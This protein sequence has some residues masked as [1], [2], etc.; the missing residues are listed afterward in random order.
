MLL[1]AVPELPAN[2]FKL[3]WVAAL[4]PHKAVSE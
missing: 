4:L 3:L 2:L 1:K